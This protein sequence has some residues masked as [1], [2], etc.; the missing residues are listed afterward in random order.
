M[1]PTLVLDFDGVLHS[2]TSGWQGVG[3]INDAPVPGAMEFL[4]EAIIDFEVNIYSSRSSSFVGR[5]A[6]KRW[7]K[8]HLFE[9][10]GAH[11]VM[12]DDLFSQIKFPS[13]KPPALVSIDDRAITFNG[14]F[15]SLLT[16]REF[17]P[18]YR[19]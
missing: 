12:G 1:K 16:L 3:V 5:R 15:P 8:K 11:P 2:Y 6:M 10:W 7:I 13:S 19:Q 18:W 4:S 9:Y 14:T 17:K